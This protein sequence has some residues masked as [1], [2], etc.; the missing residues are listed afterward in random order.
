MLAWQGTGDAETTF[1][2]AA[3]TLGFPRLALLPVPD[4]S[5][6]RFARS[7]QQLAACYPLLKPRLL[8]AMA[9][10]AGVDGQLSPRERELLASIAAVMDC[11]LPDALGTSSPWNTAAPPHPFA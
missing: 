10:A 2:H 5:L 8:K 9:Q 1:R 11:P 4:C 6:Q 3:N 7:V